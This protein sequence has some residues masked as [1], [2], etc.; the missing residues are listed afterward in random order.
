MESNPHIEP[1]KSAHIDVD[2]S[3]CGR[4][5][6][7]RP[8]RPASNRAGITWRDMS[9]VAAGNKVPAAGEN[10]DPG[11]TAISAYFH[12]A[13]I[14]TILELIPVPELKMA[15]GRQFLGR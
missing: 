10:I 15:R 8:G 5:V 12:R 11:C 3:H 9:I 1:G 6:A 4:R 7:T 14:K 2:L 13:A